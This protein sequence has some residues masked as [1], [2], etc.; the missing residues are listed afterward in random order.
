MAAKIDKAITVFSGFNVRAVV[1]FCRRAA[2]LQIPFFIIAAS[3]SDP[4][5]M[6]AYR[7]RVVRTRL[8]PQLC[9]GQVNEWL[10]EICEEANVRK[11]C[12][13]PSTEFLNRFL[14]DNVNELQ[15]HGHDVPLVSKKLYCQIS[16][17]RTFAK[18]CVEH[19]LLVPNE[20]EAMPEEPP[21]VAKPH[22]YE[23]AKTGKQLKPWLIES[24]ISFKLFLQSEDPTDYFYQELV[25]GRSIYLLYYVSRV[26]KHAI[27]S[28]ENLVQQSGGGSIVLA[29]HS[30]HY[31][32]PIAAKY[33]EMLQKI[34]FD[35]IIMV[36]LKET[37]DGRYL[38]IEANPRLWGPMQFVVDN[39]IPIL[40]QFLV[41]NGFSITTKPSLL[42]GTPFYFWSG[43]ITPAAQPLMFH[44][45]SNKDFQ[46]IAKALIA[47][48][49]FN[50]DDTRE[51]YELESK[52]TA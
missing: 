39:N 32:R 26:G 7:D 8:T 11:M 14:L 21:F 5:L 27:Y 1:A 28:Q 33:L 29:R 51:L 3:S 50:R 20:F 10:D 52:G 12:V 44:N 49:I 45:F 43:G 17:K 48:D 19:G 25:Q 41:E 35:G 6:T 23:S 46:A 42:P 16:N 13:L 15:E 24:E 22:R 9:I 18:T 4:I 38:M 2:Q 30:D 31:L 34:D 47:Y 37:D 36:E 40:D